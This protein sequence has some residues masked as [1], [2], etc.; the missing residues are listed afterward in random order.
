MKVTSLRMESIAAKGIM[1]EMGVALLAMAVALVAMAA[2][3]GR[4]RIQYEIR[5]YQDLS[6]S[7]P[8]NSLK[9][10]F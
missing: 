6:N 7:L 2:F 9:P 10:T 4:K 1:A 3:D 5:G 8:M